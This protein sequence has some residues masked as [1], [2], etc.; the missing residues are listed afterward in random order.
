MMAIGGADSSQLVTEMPCFKKLCYVI[1]VLHV[2]VTVLACV[3]RSVKSSSVGYIGRSQT[4]E[5]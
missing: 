4:F 2:Y 5:K 3:R 1:Y